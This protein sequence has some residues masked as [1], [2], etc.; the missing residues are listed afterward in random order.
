MIPFIQVFLVS[1][2]LLLI[3]AI[4]IVQGLL[5]CLVLLYVASAPCKV[6]KD[7]MV[8]KLQPLVKVVVV[9]LFAKHMGL[10]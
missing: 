5:K 10:P 4:V 2:Y 7:L 6:V 8:L 9:H 3:K 1:F